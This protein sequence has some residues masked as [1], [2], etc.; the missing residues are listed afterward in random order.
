MLVKKCGLD[1]IRAVMPIEQMDLL[2]ERILGCK[3]V[4]ARSHMS[5]ASTF[6]SNRFSVY[7]LKNY[8]C[9]TDTIKC[10]D[11]MCIHLCIMFY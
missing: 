1:D 6:R 9:T 5:K 8:T 3:S 7:K 4:K 10:A 11:F 2:D